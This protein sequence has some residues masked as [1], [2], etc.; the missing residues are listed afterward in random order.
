MSPRGDYEGA[1]TWIHRPNR[2]RGGSI[3]RPPRQRA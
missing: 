3:F 2:S 1:L